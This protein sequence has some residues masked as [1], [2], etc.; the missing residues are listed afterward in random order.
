VSKDKAASI[1]ARLLSIAKKE[2]SDFDQVL[3]R[4]ALMRSSKPNGKVFCKRTV[5]RKPASAIQST[6]C[7]ANSA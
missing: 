5:Y 7:A 3:V 4:F 6:Y 2:P 1:R